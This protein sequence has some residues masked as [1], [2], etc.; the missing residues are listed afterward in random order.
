MQIADIVTVR[1]GYAACIGS[2]V[3]TFTKRVSDRDG[4]FDWGQVTGDT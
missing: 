4:A 1:D 3:W 2:L